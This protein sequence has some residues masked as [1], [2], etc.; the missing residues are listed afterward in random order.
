MALTECKAGDTPCLCRLVFLCLHTK[1][2]SQKSLLATLGNTSS[3]SA[4]GLTKYQYTTAGLAVSE[5]YRR[6]ALR[7]VVGVPTPCCNETQVEWQ[8]YFCTFYG[9]GLGQLRQ[10][11]RVQIHKALRKH[12]MR[13]FALLKQANERTVTTLTMRGTKCK[14]LR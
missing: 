4:Q 9:Y 3:L 2:T 8:F 6:K 10:R 5:L 13:R 1:L 7:R 12:P 11:T 14:K